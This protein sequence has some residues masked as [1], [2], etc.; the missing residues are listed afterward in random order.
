MWVFFV[1]LP[2]TKALPPQKKNFPK[3]ERERK[4]NLTVWA[5]YAMHISARMKGKREKT[6]EISGSAENSFSHSFLTL[7]LFYNFTGI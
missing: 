6:R 1:T 2:T 3:G 5:A 7:P 4:P